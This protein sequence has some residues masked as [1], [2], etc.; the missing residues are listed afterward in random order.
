MGEI[1]QIGDAE[2]RR[3]VHD[4]RNSIGALVG[5]AHIL[6]TR[7]ERLSDEQRSQVID[8]MFRTAERLSKM[9]E[10]FAA[11]HRA[12]STDDA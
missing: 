12:Q 11:A 9:V 3:F 4:I 7:E 5:F 1:R 8:S 6:K 10:D 2:V